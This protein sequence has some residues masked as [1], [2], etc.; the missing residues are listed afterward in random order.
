M[1]LD[2]IYR[3]VIYN[4]MRV[5]GFDMTTIEIQFVDSDRSRRENDSIVQFSSVLLL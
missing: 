3:Y 1:E 5:M 2:S 4:V